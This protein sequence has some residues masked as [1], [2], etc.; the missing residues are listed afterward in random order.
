[1][2]RTERSCS[3]S[4]TRR[5]IRSS[6]PAFPRQLRVAGTGALAGVEAG[7]PPVERAPTSGSKCPRAGFKRQ[8]RQTGP[9]TWWQSCP[10]SAPGQHP[11]AA[12]QNSRTSYSSGSA[13]PRAGAAI[14]AAGWAVLVEPWLVV[15]HPWPVH[16]CRD[17]SFQTRLGASAFLF[18]LTPPRV[19]GAAGRWRKCARQSPRMTA[20]WISSTARPSARRMQRIR[21]RRKRRKRCTLMG[22][23]S[24]C[25]RSMPP[26]KAAMCHWDMATAGLVGHR[27]VFGEWVVAL[28]SSSARCPSVSARYIESL[29][30]P[31][32]RPLA[33]SM[34]SPSAA[35][36]I[37]SQRAASTRRR[38]GSGTASVGRLGRPARAAS[39]L[40]CLL[41]GPRWGEVSR[42]RPSRPTLCASG[43]T[44]SLCPQAPPRSYT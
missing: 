33:I 12:M 16:H 8:C 20:S 9:S 43:G 37:A 27:R 7:G 4:R 2:S 44:P 36:T 39:S 5:A 26:P 38:F 35:T 15:S 18:S 21:S 10:A 3:R 6:A 25:S 1:M 13:S 11:Y 14:H 40:G 28:G 41:Q 34:R 23:S 17:A 42:W 32:Q 30:P 24:P 29:S 19:R 31:L 22:V